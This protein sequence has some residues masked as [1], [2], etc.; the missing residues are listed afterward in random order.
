[1]AGGNCVQIL[2]QQA[3]CEWSKS[4]GKETDRSV[5]H[6][7]W[8]AHES[9][10]LA[11]PHNNLYVLFNNVF[12]LELGYIQKSVSQFVCFSDRVKLCDGLLIIK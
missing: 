2:L 3:A 8:S 1:M 12:I 5:H 10:G 6:T 4:P 11:L 7:V 9:E